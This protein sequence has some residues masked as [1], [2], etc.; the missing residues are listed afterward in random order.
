MFHYD[1]AGYCSMISDEARMNAYVS[2]LREAVTKDSVVLDLGSGTGIFS[3]LACKFGAKKVYSV[4][5]NSLV[6][7]S[8]EL[9][10]RN[11]CADKIEHI[12][13]LSSEIELDEKAD[14]L[15][16]DLHGT[17]PLFESSIVSIMDARKRLLKPGAILIPKRETIFFAVS[18]CPEVYE[19]NIERHLREIHE[20][21]MSSARHLLTNRLMNTS[22]KEM[23]L[24]TAPQIFAVLDYATIEETNYSA[25]LEFEV[26]QAGTANGLR[27]WFECELGEN[28]KTTNSLENLETIYGAPFFPFDEAVAV[29]T[30]DRI[31]VSISATLEKGEYI[32][33]WHTKIYAGKE[34]NNPKAEFVQSTLRGMFIAPKTILKQS[35][36]F[37]PTQSSE[38]KID[39]FILNKIDG[40]MMNGDIAEELQTN[41]PEKF[42]TFEE[43]L[44]RVSR[45]TQVYSE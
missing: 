16:C 20:V 45:V 23:N 37:V 43:A 7:L 40:E 2:A 42:K 5:P 22:G 30:G 13:K 41:F 26:T 32:W 11:D 18:E 14:I 36:Y 38:A 8:K 27:A 39:T 6:H 44:D 28:L 15:I 9:A 12:E 10:A 29:E 17:L 19:K 33:H 34:G 1:F 21:T 35:E 31:E 3:F 4:E 24:L 25:K